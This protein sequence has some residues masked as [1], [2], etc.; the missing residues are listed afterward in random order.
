MT[1]NTADRLLGLALLS[2]LLTAVGELLAVPLLATVGVAAFFVSLAGLL[3]SMTLSLLV[4][5]RR[6]SGPD[7]RPATRTERAR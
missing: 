3:G 5:V 7:M 6:L 4:G 1:T 2:L